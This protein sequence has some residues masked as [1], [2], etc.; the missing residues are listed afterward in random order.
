MTPE[1]QQFESPYSV[2][3]EVAAGK[4]TTIPTAVMTPKQLEDFLQIEFK[5]LAQ[6]AGVKGATVHVERAVAADYEQVIREVT[7]CLRS[8]KASAA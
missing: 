7:A 3:I 6:E 8:A 1:T 4:S 5:R 2:K